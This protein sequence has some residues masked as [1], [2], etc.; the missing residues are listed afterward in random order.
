MLP[1]DVRFTPKSGH[2][3]AP[4][5]M[6]ALCQKQTLCSA[7]IDRTY[8]GELLVRPRPLPIYNFQMDRSD[9]IRLLTA[10]VAAGMNT[11]APRANAWI[12]KKA[13]EIGLE[14]HQFVSALAYAGNE[15]WLADAARR[16]RT[17]LTRAGQAIARR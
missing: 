1:T 4:Q 10:L 6:S 8:W 12:E 16:D 2:C 5:R 11:H 3:I 9:A 13:L 7:A 17:S 14:G 15:G